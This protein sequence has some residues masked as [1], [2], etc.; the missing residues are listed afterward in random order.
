MEGDSFEGFR[1][2]V[3]AAMASLILPGWG[4]LLNAQLGKA[5]FFLFCVLTDAYLVALML[6]TPFFRYATEIRL[7]RLPTE[8]A[9]L[10]GLGAVLSGA[11]FW[12]L[13]IYDGFLV[14]RYRRPA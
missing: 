9:T 8:P 14:A 3:L 1:Q 13:S 11:L 12:I 10:V 7:D 4:Q 6:L 5:L 2:P